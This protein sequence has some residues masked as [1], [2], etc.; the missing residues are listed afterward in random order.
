MLPSSPDSLSSSLRCLSF[1][2]HEGPHL[3]HLD[4]PHLKASHELVVDLLRMSAN[5]SEDTSDGVPCY[6]CQSR[7]LSYSD[8]LRQVLD[9]VDDLAPCKLK[10]EQRSMPTLRK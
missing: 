6:A 9:D 5:R 3:V 8:S 7:R 2:S 4:L 10:L 1:F